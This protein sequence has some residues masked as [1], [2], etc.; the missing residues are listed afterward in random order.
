M[1]ILIV[2]YVDDN[3]GDN[4]IR[5]CFEQLLKVV[6]KNTKIE[7]Y[8]IRKMNLKQIDPSLVTTSD[9][10]FFAGGGLFGLSYLNFFDY[11]DEITALADQKNIPVIFSSIGVNNMDATEETEEKL[12]TIINRKCI[13]QIAVREN[14]ELFKK[15]ASKRKDLKITQVC[16]PAVW[17]KYIYFH[18]N[19]KEKE[20]NPIIGINV[21]RGG[22]FKDNN[23]S[24]VLKDELEYLNSLKEV[25]EKNHIDYRFY[26]NGSFLDNNALHYFAKE[27]HI[28]EN[29][30]IF[31]QST[32]EFVETV[33]SFDAIAAI[34][35][36][37]AI[38]SYSLDIPS[39]GLIWNDKIPLFY[40]YIGRE[41]DAIS[42]E[43]WKASD[44]FDKLLIL[45]KENNCR[46]DQNYLM[47][48]YQF[49]YNVLSNQGKKSVSLFPFS[50]VVEELSKQELSSLED[51]TDYRLKCEKSEI[52]Y[53]TRFSQVLK[54][55]DEII[56][57]KEKIE[58]QKQT[59]EKQ[60]QTIQKQ[61]DRLNHIDNIFLVKIY[62]KWKKIIKK[63]FH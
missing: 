1:K 44:V 38:V 9:I 24:W 16:D 60:K 18:D 22:L 6:L 17:T 13:K 3:F 19:S 36:H 2:S 40:K 23:K 58:K 31:P 61:K 50:K 34:R 21:V 55:K 39:V 41:N 54:K 37:S 30:L 51:L 45:L 20:S 52:H 5:I 33:N 4:L 62:H 8:E 42:L 63:I 10:I 56:K 7:N 46:A 53:L 49:L 27:Y 26:T 15:F 35:M 48:V 57:L 14:M 47:T 43:N 12:K 32:R 29:K 11:L 59:I 28:E 25:C